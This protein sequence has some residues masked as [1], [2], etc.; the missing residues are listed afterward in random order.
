MAVEAS[1]CVDVQDFMPFATWGVIML[2]SWAFYHIST[3][4]LKRVSFELESLAIFMSGTG[5]MMLVR[6]VFKQSLVQAAAMA[7]GMVCFAIII[8]VIENPDRIE[9]SE[10]LFICWLWHFWR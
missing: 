7:A 4:A 2:I 1:L 3:K 5:I 6:Q 9:N 10:Y 8:K